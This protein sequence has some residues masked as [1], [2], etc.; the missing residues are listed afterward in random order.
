MFAASSA[1]VICAS[2][3]FASY[4]GGGLGGSC[5]AGSPVGEGTAL[6]CGVLRVTCAANEVVVVV[7][8]CGGGE[9]SSGMH[10]AATNSASVA[11]P[12]RSV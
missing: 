9:L 11:R 3:T 2:F 5:E 10:P 7:L 12:R 8:V 6:G 1:A 4:V